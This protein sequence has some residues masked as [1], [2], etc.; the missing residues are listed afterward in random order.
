MWDASGFSC[1]PC[2]LSLL[3]EEEEESQ[4]VKDLEYSIYGAGKNNRGKSAGRA[5]CVGL[6]TGAVWALWLLARGH[7]GEFGS[8]R[9]SSCVVVNHKDKCTA[10]YSFLG[11]TKG[12]VLNLLLYQ[13]P[14][15]QF[16][17]LVGVFQ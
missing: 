11:M 2:L 10:S 13:G 4:M 15:L 3:Q 5:D 9:E 14:C 1:V 8:I 16:S 17:Y 12:I 7:P 6:G